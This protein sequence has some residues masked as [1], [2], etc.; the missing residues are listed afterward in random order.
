[1]FFAGRLADQ[2]KLST[3][4]WVFGAQMRETALQALAPLAAEVVLCDDNRP[5]LG[6]LVWP[7]PA[8]IKAALGM[9]VGEALTSGALAQAAKERLA[10][11]NASARGASERI[12]RLAFLTTPPDPNAHEV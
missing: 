5:W 8:G 7:S 12:V 4:S 10:A 1:V 3:G 6:L 2:F 11:H 9:E